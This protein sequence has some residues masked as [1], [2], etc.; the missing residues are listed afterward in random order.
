MI[1]PVVEQPDGTFV[2]NFLG[3]VRT[4][5]TREESEILENNIRESGYY[6]YRTGKG[7]VGDGW[8]RTYNEVTTETTAAGWTLPDTTSLYGGRMFF[9]LI[10]VGGMKVPLSPFHKD[11]QGHPLQSSFQRRL[12]GEDTRPRSR[13]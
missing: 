4:M 13:L 1:G 8:N 9:S 2:A 11:L 12:S 10:T 5:K 6:P 3:T 7:R